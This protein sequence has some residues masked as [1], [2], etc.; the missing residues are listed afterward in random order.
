[1]AIQIIY[2]IIIFLFVFKAKPI[3]PMVQYMVFPGQDRWRP[4]YKAA[5]DSDNIREENSIIESQAGFNTDPQCPPLRSRITFV[6][7]CTRPKLDSKPGQMQAKH[8][9]F[10]QRPSHRNP[11]R[12]MLGLLLAIP[13]GFVPRLYMARTSDLAELRRATPVTACIF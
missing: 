12:E 2:K 13:H 4:S 10:T 5:L 1:M 6:M 8:W 7:A 11:H 9:N 3:P